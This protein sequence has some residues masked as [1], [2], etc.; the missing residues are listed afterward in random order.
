MNNEG[1]RATAR[2]MLTD[3]LGN[4][5]IGI[6]NGVTAEM[7]LNK[8][9]IFKADCDAYEWSKRYGCATTELNVVTQEITRI[10]LVAGG[11]S[12]RPTYYFIAR[13]GNKRE[14]G[15]ILYKKVSK[16]TGYMKTVRSTSQNVINKDFIDAK[17][18]ASAIKYLE[19]ISRKMEQGD[20]TPL[21]GF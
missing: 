10:G 7:V 4:Y 5:L 8:M 9:G 20:D 2:A 3:D 1:L 19:S 6:E 18:I 12:R 14:E 17:K 11:M 16:A 21:L 13:K 15:L